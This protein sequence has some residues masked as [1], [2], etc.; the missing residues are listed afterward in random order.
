MGLF[1]GGA[2][3]QGRKNT[4]RPQKPQRP[5]PPK[6]GSKQGTKGSPK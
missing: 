2:K 6:G 3:N 1:G 5:K 4:G